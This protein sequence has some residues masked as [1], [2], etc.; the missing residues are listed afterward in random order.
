MNPIGREV[1]GW[2]NWAARSRFLA[3]KKRA[4]FTPR[5][6]PK[7][8]YTV[9][10]SA[11]FHQNLRGA[12]T[13]ASSA[14]FSLEQASAPSRPPGPAGHVPAIRKL[15]LES[16]SRQFVH[17]KTFARRGA[18]LWP[19]P[20]SFV[21]G[22][23]HRSTRWTRSANP[24]FIKPRW[25]AVESRRTVI[26]RELFR[27]AR[28]A[29]GFSPVR[30][31]WR[32]S[33]RP[34]RRSWRWVRRPCR[35]CIPWVPVASAGAAAGVAASCASASN[36][37]SADDS[38]KP[39]AA[40]S[41]SR[42]SAFRREIISILASSFISGLPVTHDR[43]ERDFLGPNRRDSQRGASPIR[44]CWL[45]L[46]AGRMARAILWTFES[47]WSRLLRR[48]SP[49]MVAKTFMVCVASVVKWSRAT[50][51]WAVRRR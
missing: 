4:D 18:G 20:I 42:E 37:S 48:A 49:P 27:Q 31:P 8:T 33:W 15:R 17:H 16:A 9:T 5:S 32:R 39:N 3:T 19:P 29:A 24:T 25:Q 7:R 50:A 2:R 46:E 47:G 23:A 51:P 11:A 10:W 1:G 34:C 36:G 41:P 26:A 6:S 13:M 35:R 28:V 38:V 43:L 40:P 45:G 12:R 14:R 44:R 22:L 21:C 30:R